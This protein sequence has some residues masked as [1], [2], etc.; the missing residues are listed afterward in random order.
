ML[1]VLGYLLTFQGT[2]VT[3]E[4]RAPSVSPPLLTSK[5]AQI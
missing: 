1:V 3:A 5:F 4:V 2:W